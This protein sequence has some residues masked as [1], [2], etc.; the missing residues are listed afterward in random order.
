MTAPARASAS[1]ASGGATDM[2]TARE[3]NLV[4]VLVSIL[5]I[6]GGGLLV[7]VL[8]LQPLAQKKDQLLALEKDITEKNR[9][10]TQARA[11][12]KKMK[13]WMQASLPPDVDLAQ[14]EYEKFLSDLPRK[15]GARGGDFTVSAPRQI[16]TKSSPTLPGKGPIYT[17]LPF[18]IQGHGTVPTVVKLLENFHK[19][20]LLHQIKNINL[21]RPLTLGPQQRPNEIDVRLTV[22]ALVVT[23]APPRKTLLTETKAEN[24]SDGPMFQVS[25]AP[26][27]DYRSV[28]EKN[29]FYGPI[30]REKEREPNWDVIRYVHLTDI[31][32][33]ERRTEAF[34]FDRYNNQRTRLRASV[35][36]DSFKIRDAAG[37][38]LVAGKVV[39]I[40]E[41]DVLFESDA[42]FYQI[43]IGQSLDE[44]MRKPVATLENLDKF[45]N[46]IGVGPVW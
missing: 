20:P 45:L 44:A 12:A 35:G 16:D 30:F 17:K 39:R 19:A 15:S 3:R 29:V 14:R 8:Y 1:R 21:Q 5:L 25:L 34:L 46:A 24:G 42:K 2:S 28:P 32:T 6:G 4:V 26:E 41:R 10:I 9:R 38:E 22:E 11:N 43:H 36:F 37:E 27:R 31:T 18:T 40:D 13:G 23:G 7:N 33:N